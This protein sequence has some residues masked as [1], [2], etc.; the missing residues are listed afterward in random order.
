MMRRV[1]RDAST[2]Q[3]NEMEDWAFS[4]LEALNAN[5][6]LDMLH[7]LGPK[8]GLDPERITRAM[9][10]MEQ[11]ATLNSLPYMHTVI[12]NL[13]NLGLITERTDAQWRKA[14]M[15][16]ESQPGVKGTPVAAS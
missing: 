16:V 9:L 6:Q 4:I 7:A 1:V 14:G 12:P 13:R 5:Q 2:E 3:K 11:W 10:G 8:Y 15:M